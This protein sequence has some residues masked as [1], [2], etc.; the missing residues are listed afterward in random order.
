MTKEEFEANY[1]ALEKAAESGQMSWRFAMAKA[2]LLACEYEQMKQ[3]T[4]LKRLDNLIASIEENYGE[5]QDEDG[6][7]TIGSIDS[8]LLLEDLRQVR[9]G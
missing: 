7:A 4:L 1:N 8:D 3:A 5:V 6:L 9:N 2:A